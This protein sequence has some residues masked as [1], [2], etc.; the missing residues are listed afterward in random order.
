M[1][2]WSVLYALLLAAAAGLVP[3]ACYATTGPTPSC[4]SPN[5]P[6]GCYPQVNDDRTLF[7]VRKDGGR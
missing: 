4:T 7:A 1:T 2:R 6:D 5:P 3:W